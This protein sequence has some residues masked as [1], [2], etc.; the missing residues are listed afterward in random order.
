MFRQIG[1]RAEDQDWQRILWRAEPSAEVREYR[2]T[3]VTYGTASAPYLVLRVLRQLAEDER[4]RFPLGSQVIRD[5][6]YVDDILAGGDTL[7]QTWEV[8]QQLEGILRS[9]GFPLDRWASNIPNLGDDAARETSLFQESE[10]HGALGLQWN[11]TTDS[12]TMKGPR[13][14]PLASLDHWTKRTALSM[15]AS[16]FDPLGWM[17]PVLIQARILLQ[18]L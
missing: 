1:V 8:R 16:L 14:R 3:S 10:I 18:D 6:S 9:G 12:L 4:D 15:V 17:A 11:T 5:H 13:C 7:K 2:L